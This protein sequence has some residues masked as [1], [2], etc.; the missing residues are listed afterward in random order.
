VFHFCPMH[1]RVVVMLEAKLDELPSCDNYVVG[2]ASGGHAQ[3]VF[4]LLQ[5]IH[6]RRSA[7]FLEMSSEPS[8][9]SVYVASVMSLNL[10][11][12]VARTFF[13]FCCYVDLV[14]VKEQARQIVKHSY[15]Q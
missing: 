3:V 1:K 13:G 6:N 11:V 12:Y 9:P 4:S 2:F 5:G 10:L 15:S 8:K 14:A 7:S